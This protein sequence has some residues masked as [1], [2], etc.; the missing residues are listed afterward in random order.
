M[1]D[2]LKRDV[3][4]DDLYSHLMYPQVFTDF[5]RHLREYSDVS[6][7]PTPPFF[8]PAAREEISVAI[9]AGKTLII[10]LVNVSEPDKDGRHR[11]LRIEWHHRETRDGQ[12]GPP[13]PGRG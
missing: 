3:T 8:R 10:R 7:L 1:A 2:K 9:E 5:S 4:D 12:E 6:V 13:P 11:D